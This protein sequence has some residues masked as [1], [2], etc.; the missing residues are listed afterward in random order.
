MVD[1]SPPTHFADEKARLRKAFRTAR[2]AHVEALPVSL[3]ALILSR[4][5]A[6]VAETMPQ[7]QTIG[8]YYPV[9]AEAPSL[10]WARWLSENG[11]QVA[12]PWFAS[13]EAPMQ[14]RLW[15]NP[16][17]ED[18]LAPGPWRAPQP[19]EHATLITPETVIVP[20][21]AFTSSGH[22]LGQGGGHYDRWLESN[23]A[24]RAIGLAWDCQLAD[25]LPIEAHDRA[26]AAVVTPT[27]IFEGAD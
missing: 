12:L 9:G 14:F 16:F 4:P 17:D 21:V 2:A 26:L 20:L 13:R 10:G 23:P 5:P 24:A 3:R 27:R 1:P 11:R 25:E 18:D 6:P 22:R 19:P 15:D 8:L 7:G